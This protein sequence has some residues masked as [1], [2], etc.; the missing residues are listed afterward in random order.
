MRGATKIWSKIYHNGW[1]KKPQWYQI[2]FWFKSKS[3]RKT[4][5][6]YLRNHKFAGADIQTHER[7]KIS[8]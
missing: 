1:V 8:P 7:L 6:K 3:K 5:L 4:Q 2:Y